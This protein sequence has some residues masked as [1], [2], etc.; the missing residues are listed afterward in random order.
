[1]IQLKEVSKIYKMGQEKVR[2]LDHVDM[3][4]AEGEYVSITGLPE[5][6]NQQL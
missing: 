4:I 3:C 5:A 2:A 1:M 6:E